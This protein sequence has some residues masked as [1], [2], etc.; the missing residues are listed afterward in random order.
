MGCGLYRLIWQTSAKVL[1]SRPLPPPIW[2]PVCF[3][4]KLTKFYGA[5][6]ISEDVRKKYRSLVPRWFRL[7]FAL[8]VGLYRKA[9]MSRLQA[10]LHI[11]DWVVDSSLGHSPRV[12]HTRVQRQVTEHWQDAVEI[13]NQLA[14]N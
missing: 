6:E 4:V 3:G 9:N 7:Q 10:P 13:A 14:E 5:L 12:C 1:V 2:D 8:K 11:H